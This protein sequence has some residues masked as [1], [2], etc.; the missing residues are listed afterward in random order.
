MR[1]LSLLLAFLFASPAFAAPAEPYDGLTYNPQPYMYWTYQ[2]QSGRCNN[3]ADCYNKATAA[4]PAGFPACTLKYSWTYQSLGLDKQY[5]SAGWYTYNSAYCQT[6]LGTENNNVDPNIGIYSFD[7]LYGEPTGTNCP[8]PTTNSCPPTYVNENFSFDSP[9]LPDEACFNN[10]KY[11]NYSTI[12][13]VICTGEGCATGVSNGNYKSL[14]TSC[15]GP[16]TSGMSR[17]NFTGTQ[18]DAGSKSCG[19][20]NANG[21]LQFCGYPAPGS[22]Q[23]TDTGFGLICGADAPSPPAPANTE[24]AKPP[25]SG[26]GKL[27]QGGRTIQFYNVQTVQSNPPS[28][29]TGD[30][31]NGDPGGEPGG[32]EC[33]VSGKPPCTVRIDETGVNPNAAPDAAT[34][35]PYQS[36]LDLDLIP[37]AIEG[38]GAGSFDLPIEPQ[39][40]KTI[41]FNWGGEQ[42]DFPPVG[43][44]QRI[45]TVK[46]AAGWALSF[47]VAFS[48]LMAALRALPGKSEAV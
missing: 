24:G 43:W 35:D 41:P 30:P 33:G 15:T 11:E 14:A 34:A 37:D 23:C 44:C 19:F 42:F 36:A 40:C 27:G 2:A 12:E 46:G 21:Q 17:T 4:V 31:V 45:E 8:P 47:W 48:C 18:R 28:N 29:G 7:C 3:P 26:S 16:N 6:V 39:T 25:P 1:T 38:E 20:I 32:T 22:V 10:C 9:Q 5:G 13:V